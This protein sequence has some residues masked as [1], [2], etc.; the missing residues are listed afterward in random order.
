MNLVRLAVATQQCTTEHGIT[1]YSGILAELYLHIGDNCR[2]CC[3]RL[4]VSFSKCPAPDIVALLL[5]VVL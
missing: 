5:L 4:G 2:Q 3:L 1:D